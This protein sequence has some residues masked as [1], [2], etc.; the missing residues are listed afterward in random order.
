MGTTSPELCLTGRR[1]TTWEA[2]TH[3]GGDAQAHSGQ[4]T[5]GSGYGQSKEALLLLTVFL[6]R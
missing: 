2:A 1:Q 3:E 4:A 6:A 5:T